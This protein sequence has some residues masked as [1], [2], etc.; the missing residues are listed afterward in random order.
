MAC[1]CQGC[2]KSYDVD[3]LVPDE[4]WELIKP[5]YKPEGSGLLCGSCICSRLEG[6][7]QAGALRMEYTD[8][9][10]I[11]SDLPDINKSE[12]EEAINW[13]KEEAML[14]PTEARHV[15]ILVNA[16][17][18]LVGELKEKPFIGTTHLHLL[19]SELR[20]ADAEL[21][22]LEAMSQY[23]SIMMPGFAEKERKAR[24]LREARMKISKLLSLVD[25]IYN[26]YESEGR[27]KSEFTSY[28]LGLA[29]QK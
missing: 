28:L 1:K 20:S 5:E 23:S 3:I 16:V 15:S 25:G 11:P 13:S 29:G 2:G 17:F 22:R 19:R 9:P 21:M 4:I 8:T 12:L 27:E 6:L 14:N 24:A 26:R 7:G 18:N 10:A